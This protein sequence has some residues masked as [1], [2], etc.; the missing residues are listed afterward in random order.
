MTQS[1]HNRQSISSNFLIALIAQ[2]GCL[3]LVIIIASLLG[4][5]WLDKTFGTRP[6]FTLLLLLAGT[7]ISVIVMLFVSRRAVAKIKSQVDKKE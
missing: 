5:L 4:G 7:P 3:T 2:V 1:D 6:L